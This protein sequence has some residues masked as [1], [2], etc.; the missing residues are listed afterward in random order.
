VLRGLVFPHD[1]NLITGIEGSED[2]GVYRL[3]DDLALVQTLDFFTPIVDDPRDYGRM[4]A[5]NSLSDVYAMGGRPITALNI[6]AFPKDKVPL[7]VLHEILAGGL[8]ACTEAGVAVLGGHSMQN[9]DPFFGLSVTGVVD[10]RRVLTNSGLRVGDRLILTKPVGTGVI[11][12]WIKA[13]DAPPDVVQAATH[14]MQALNRV[15]SEVAVARGATGCTDITGFGLVGHLS[16]MVRAS[17]VRAR[18]RA[19]DV[20]LL[21][22]A[23]QAVALGKVPGGGKANRLFFAGWTTRDP[24]VT[25]ETVTL[26]NDPQ[27]SGGLLFGVAPD[28]V[29]ASLED[30]CAAGVSAAEIG[31]VLAQ[32]EA[33]HIE[34]VS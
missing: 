30:L 19:A 22:G 17:G 5:A 8:E 11:G 10:P 34:I 3:S 18:L 15:A 27:T 26:L 6:V 21:P 28:Q 4:A 31:R 13:G 33:G 29:D 9:D 1:P 12:T 2:A 23:L 20:P 7:E 32:D 24:A 16:E 25:D 14:S